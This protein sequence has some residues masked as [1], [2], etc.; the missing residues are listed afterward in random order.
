MG[1]KRPNGPAFNEMDLSPGIDDFYQLTALAL[2]DVKLCSWVSG[3]AV[4]GPSIINAQKT[5][6]R[7][8]QD[9]IIIS[10]LKISKSVMCQ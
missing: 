9:T 6:D 1:R 3:T 7:I 2:V 8:F 5:Q 4:G 10:S